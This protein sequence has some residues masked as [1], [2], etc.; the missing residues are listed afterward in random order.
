MH[1]PTCTRGARSH[2]QP[3]TKHRL[4]KRG[5]VEGSV[6]EKRGEVERSVLEKRGEVEGSVLEKG[7][8]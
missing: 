3:I 8:G 5:E 7:V 2:H 4:E 6:L 1:S